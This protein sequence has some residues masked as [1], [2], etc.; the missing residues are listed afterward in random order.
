[1]KIG[2]NIDPVLDTVSHKA[3]NEIL[4][5]SIIL[6]T[7]P[8]LRLEVTSR[9]ICTYIQT[10]GNINQDNMIRE[11]GFMDSHTC[12]TLSWRLMTCEACSAKMTNVINHGYLGLLDKSYE[13]NLCSF[14]KNS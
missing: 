3:F 1:M 4:L 9:P 11:N 2:R 7:L 6:T 5:I 14:L 10:R 13:I 12:I 8:C